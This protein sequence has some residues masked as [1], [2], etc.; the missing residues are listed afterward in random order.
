VLFRS[1]ALDGAFDNFAADNIFKATFGGS[2]G[3]ITFG[4]VTSPGLTEDFL[5][6]DLSVVG[7]INGGG[8]LG[9][10][11]LVYIPEPTSSGLLIIGLCFAFAAFRRV[12]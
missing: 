2:F 11:D 4:A 6:G 7:S 12:H 1:D 3:S 8:D 5:A 9:D 10:V